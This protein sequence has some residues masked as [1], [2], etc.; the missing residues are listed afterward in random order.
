MKTSK[1]FTLIEIMIVVAIVGIVLAVAIP[2][3]T[4]NNITSSV[5]CRGGYEFDRSSN[6]Q[7]IGV[8]GGGI[9]CGPGQ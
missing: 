8:N 7:I 6:R 5:S 1:G 4:G 2:A 3:I 9:P